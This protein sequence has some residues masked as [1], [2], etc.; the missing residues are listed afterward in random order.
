MAG[1]D[2]LGAV[3]DRTIE[4]LRPLCGGGVVSA[5]RIERCPEGAYDLVGARYRCGGGIDCEYVG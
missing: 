2:R 5:R 3:T 1:I 4:S